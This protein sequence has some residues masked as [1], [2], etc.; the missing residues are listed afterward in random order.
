MVLASLLLIAFA[1]WPAAVVEPPSPPAPP[2]ANEPAPAPSVASA[3]AAASDATFAPVRES[4]QR[5]SVQLLEAGLGAPLALRRLRVDGDLATTTMDGRLELPLADVAIGPDVD[6]DGAWCDPFV[7]LRDAANT[8]DVPCY[9][10]L[11]IGDAVVAPHVD[12][13]VRIVDVASVP[14]GEIQ[15]WLAADAVDAATMP[16]SFAAATVRGRP[17]ERFRLRSGRTYF[18]GA[19][20]KAPAV[21]QPG[22]H[23]LVGTWYEVDGRRQFVAG[24]NRRGGVRISSGLPVFPA[25]VTDV[26]LRIDG[27][28]AIAVHFDALAA[29]TDARV[30]WF[31]RTK[32]DEGVAG[33]AWR[34]VDSFTGRLV[35]G[36]PPL[37]RRDL[38]HGSYRVTASLATADGI[39]VMAWQCEVGDVAI[40]LLQSRYPGRHELEVR[41]REPGRRRALVGLSGLRLPGASEG[42]ADLVLLGDVDVAGDFVVR[43]LPCTSG[44]L[45]LLE[46]DAPS[47]SDGPFHRD[48]DLVRSRSVGL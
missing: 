21:L 20:G 7:V 3:Q 40:E 13:D 2:A 16:A 9:G 41:G 38:A 12:V 19:F 39:D 31:R 42:D 47:G 48:F 37:V 17:G 25:V 10:W 34:S 36:G 15:A 4:P 30:Q 5:R 44:A 22:H 27:L 46:R 43:G 11:Q 33:E 6:R 32:P 45:M 29:D 8:F 28:G 23:S 26:P 18:V 1:W 24:V 14:P 35:K